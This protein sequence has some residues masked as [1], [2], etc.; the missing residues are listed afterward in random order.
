MRLAGAGRR[1]GVIPTD[2]GVR[3]LL[4]S[5]GNILTQDKD[6]GYIPLWLY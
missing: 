4:W 5:D 6:R 1:A 3:G 2:Q